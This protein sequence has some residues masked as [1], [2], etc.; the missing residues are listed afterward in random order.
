M[1]QIHH[2]EEHARRLVLQRIGK[3]RRRTE[4]AVLGN[5]VQRAQRLASLREAVQEDRHD[6][7]VN[8]E[9]GA[10]YAVD[11]LDWLIEVL[12]VDIG[13]RP[14]LQHQLLEQWHLNFRR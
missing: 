10:D 1:I 14:Q 3:N 5:A 7:T 4:L 2:P 8:A 12:G 13:N 6:Y 11:A 9:L